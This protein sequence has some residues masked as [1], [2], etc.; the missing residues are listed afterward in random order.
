MDDD[1]PP[2]DE[3]L[4]EYMYIADDNRTDQTSVSE[5]V[6]TTLDEIRASEDPTV[7]VV[8]ML[9]YLTVAPGEKGVQDLAHFIWDMGAE[10]CIAYTSGYL[11]DE[12]EHLSNPELFVAYRTKTV[13]TID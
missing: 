10:G 8:P 11:V 6:G 7:V 12:Y 13:K 2:L 1:Y 9:L 3:I 4:G 5:F